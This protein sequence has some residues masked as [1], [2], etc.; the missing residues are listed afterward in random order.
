M[1]KIIPHEEFIRIVEQEKP[2]RITGTAIFMDSNPKGTPQALLHNL[3]HNKVLHERVILLTLITGERPRIP[4]EERYEL[5]SLGKNIFR[6]NISIGFSEDPNVPSLLEEYDFDQELDLGKT[7][8]FLGRETMLATRKP[9]M[10]MWREK[11]FARM[12]RNARCAASYFN[13]PSDRVVEIGTQ[14]EL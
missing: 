6:M 13:I 2:E 7:T 14:V 4:R 9:G 3:I 5:Q 12:S 10:A 11:I 1:K 8:F